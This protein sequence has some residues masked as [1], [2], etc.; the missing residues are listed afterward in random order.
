MLEQLQRHNSLNA[1]K[2]SSNNTGIPESVSSE[3]NKAL[4][5]EDP[6][7]LPIMA[8]GPPRLGKSALITLMSGFA[9]KLGATVVL[10]VGPNKT[11]PLAEMLGKY[12]EKLQYTP[13]SRAEIE[14]QRKHQTQQE[15]Q[16]AAGSASQQSGARAPPLFYPCCPRASAR[17]R[18]QN[19]TRAR[20]RARARAPVRPYAAALPRSRPRVLLL[21]RRARRTRAEE[22]A[23]DASGTRDSND[24]G[25]LTTTS[26]TT[27]GHL[28]PI[29]RAR[30]SHSGVQDGV[31]MV[32]M[33]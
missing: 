23:H 16:D 30:Q 32:Q 26:W 18:R 17:A 2:D 31:A 15:Q 8:C 5:I 1:L 29:V 11:I 7:M 10:G 22:N 21:L 27:T 9:I 28:G 24:A 20:A 14:Q 4:E 3:W 33:V 6:P 25:L 12:T 13:L 19:R